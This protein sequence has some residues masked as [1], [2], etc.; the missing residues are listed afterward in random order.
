MLEMQPK[1]SE[2]LDFS[3]FISYPIHRSLLL[4][5]SPQLCIL[6]LEKIFSV[7]NVGSVRGKNSLTNG[8]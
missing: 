6:E 8:K 1:K 3:G 2:N 5:L 4:L 7:S